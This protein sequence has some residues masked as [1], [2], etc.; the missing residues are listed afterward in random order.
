[1]DVCHT[2]VEHGADVNAKGDQPNTPLI[3]AVDRG[4]LAAAEFLITNKAQIDVRTDNGLTP[5]TMAIIKDQIEMV[6]LLLDNRA[7]AN[8]ESEPPKESLSPLRWAISGNH[9]QTVQLL[10]E[11]GA[12]PNAVESDGDTALSDAIRQGNVDMVRALI[13]HGA[14]VNFLD[15]QGRPPLAQLRAA[16]AERHPGPQRAPSS[17]QQ[18]G[19]QIEELLLKAGA[20]PD[21]DRRRAIWT[22]GDDGT[23]KHEVFQCPSNSINHYTLLEFLAALYEVDVPKDSLDLKAPF[24]SR[25]MYAHGDAVVQFPEFARVTIHRLEGKREE[26]LHVNVAEILLSSD[27]SKDV[28]L[29]AGD[30]VE[31]AKQEHKVADTWYGLSAAQITALHKCLL[32]TVKIISQGHTNELALLPLFADAALAEQM[33]FHVPQAPLNNMFPELPEILKGRK[34]DTVVRSFLLAEV[35]RDAKVLLNT[36][37]LSRVRLARGGTKMTFDL[38]ANPAPEVLLKDGDVIEIPEL[39]ASAPVTEAK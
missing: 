17:L 3:L 14:D 33:H 28:A 19:P 22:Y 39:G 1:L 10:L 20:D 11:H 38:T 29:Q 30:L 37:D 32:R 6:K 2:L 18:T 13:E 8:L 9:P 34:V 5:L 26:V 23:P 24:N 31:I 16:L 15:K 35:V 21:Y 12:K 4:N 25:G 36:W 7:D 27:G